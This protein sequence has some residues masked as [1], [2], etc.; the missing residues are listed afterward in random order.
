MEE[1]DE[2]VLSSG[3]L[4]EDGRP[5]ARARLT[6]VKDK[7]EKVVEA[8][9]GA[10]IPVVF[11][12]GIMGTNLK[13]STTGDVVWRPP[14]LDGI[15]PVLGALGQMFA[16]FFR[17]AAT[18]QRL[19]NPEEVEVD[20]RGAVDAENMISEELAR[21]RGWGA[22]MRSAYNPVMAEMHRK[23]NDIMASAKLQPWWSEEGARAPAD[24]GEEKGGNEALTA[25]QCKH[26]AHYRFE[27]WGGGYNWLKSNRDSGAAI[28]ERIDNVILP[29][30]AE[31]GIKAQKVILVTHS[32]GGL[33]ARVVSKVNNY[34]KLLGISHGVMPATGAA[35]T[36]HH[37]RAGY[38][39][40]SSVILGRNAGEVV[41]ILAH[42]PGG[43]ELLPA[44][45]YNEGNP[46]L[47]L[48]DNG[49]R[50]PA[51]GNPYG[52][53]YLST[54]WYG[55]VPEG[56]T[57]LL[58][59]AGAVGKDLTEREKED[60]PAPTPRTVFAKNIGDVMTFHA[61]ILQKYHT[62]SFVHYG[63]DAKRLSWGSVTWTGG[64]LSDIQTAQSVSDNHN[65][66]VL[67]Q[68][69]GGTARLEIA[70]ELDPGDETVP[71]CSGAAPKAWVTGCFRQ[72]S[73]G[74]GQYAAEGKKGY[75]H[76]KSYNDDR[77]R[78]ATLY[79]VVRLSQAANW[80]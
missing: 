23:L 53:I 76:Q 39:G 70:D 9:T 50:L 56:N 64:N 14:N 3:S 1:K 68:G 20:D 72:G 18:R 47:E 73:F 52:E 43:L 67:L 54:Q 38:T 22:L 41:S 16:Y 5:V 33:V 58:D 71:A 2:V 57:G 77:A 7:R 6:H 26:A 40:V 30:Y 4:D 36:Y 55:L 63:E 12:P 59:P 49:P 66:R 80:A 48:G 46:W 61:D 28:I 42:A 8:D 17:G 27:V 78:W 74:T 45:D 25:E 21:E 75:E 65:G 37:C 15:G 35:A 24:Y 10:V 60:G 51:S 34:D 11:L 13:S 29:Y 69:A 32:M 44:M 79:S 31:R 62:P 19:L